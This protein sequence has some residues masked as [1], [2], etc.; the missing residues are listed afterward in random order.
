MIVVRV[1]TFRRGRGL[2]GVATLG[3][4]EGVAAVAPCDAVYPGAGRV[5]RRRGGSA[6]TPRGHAAV[7]A[8]TMEDR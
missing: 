7:E 6:S 2:G 1:A 3:V 8:R 4:A 5:P